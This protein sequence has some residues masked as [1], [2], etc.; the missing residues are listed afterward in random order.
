MLIGHYAPA[1]VLDRIRPVGNVGVSSAET[2]IRR[3]SSR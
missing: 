1:P 2:A 3:S